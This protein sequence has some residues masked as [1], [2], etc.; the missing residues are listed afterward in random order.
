MTSLRRVLMYG[1]LF[2][3]SIA[4]MSAAASAA[5]SS[6]RSSTV[7]RPVIGKPTTVPAQAMAGKRFT[8]SF[9]VTR[10]DN[11][12]PLTTG[13]MISDPSSAAKVIAHAQSFRAGTARLSFIVPT[14][15]RQVRVKVT[16]KTGTTSATRVANYRVVQIPK[17]A[18]SIGDVSVAEGNSGSTTMSFP[19][20]LSAPSTQPVSVGYSTTDGTAVAP[21]DYTTASGMLA[22][23]PGETTK[24]IAVSVVGDTT[25]ESDETLTVT[26]SNPVNA[27]IA[28][29]TATGTIT[30]DDVAAATPGHFAGTIGN[31]RSPIAFDIGAD[32]RTLSNWTTGELDMS[33]D[34]NNYTA[35]FPNI[36]QPGPFSVAQDGSFTISG[37]NSNSSIKFTGKVT[38]TTGAGIVHVEASF[39]VGGSQ[40]NCSSG[41]QPWTASKV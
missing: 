9:K 2:L 1:G 22:F 14:T 18:V 27:T 36:N 24:S 28:D 33:C 15:A 35:Y 30:N 7:V 17:P 20:T 38:G 5:S 29:A 39:P 37:S 25:V 34:P 3:L 23:K 4:A 6:A 31:A 8:V 26:I 40:V 21:G 12:K 41:D 16:I 32:G 10:S 13:T 19:V 11:G